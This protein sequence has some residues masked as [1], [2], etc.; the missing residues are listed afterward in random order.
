MGELAVTPGVW[1]ALG[2]LALAYLTTIIAAAIRL[3]ALTN[4]IENLS[5]EI[6]EI[7]DQQRKSEAVEAVK[8]DALNFKMG[9]LSRLIK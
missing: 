3:G 1:I 4:K 8:W 7:K 5:K 6:A 2:M 9:Q